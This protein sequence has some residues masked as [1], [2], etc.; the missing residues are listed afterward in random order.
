METT[1]I[2]KQIKMLDEGIDWGRNFIKE[3]AEEQEE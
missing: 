1:I 2:E 3:D